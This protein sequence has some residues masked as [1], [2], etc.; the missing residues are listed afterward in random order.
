MANRI[1]VFRDRGAEVQDERN[2]SSIAA[3]FASCRDVTRCGSRYLDGNAGG[4]L[5]ARD[6]CQNAPVPYVQATES[7]LRLG[8]NPTVPGLIPPNTDFFSA[9][10][11]QFRDYIINASIAAPGA[12]AL[13]PGQSPIGNIG[14]PADFLPEAAWSLRG[15]SWIAEVAETADPTASMEYS[16]TFPRIVPIYDQCG[17]EIGYRA[18]ATVTM[19]YLTADCQ[20]ILYA[21]HSANFAYN[22]NFFTNPLTVRTVIDQL[23]TASYPQGGPPSI[24]TASLENCATLSQT[25]LTNW[26]DVNIPLL[27]VTN[28]VIVA[29][30]N[31]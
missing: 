4:G 29:D 2:G 21:V 6:G 19:T 16:L 11:T 8:D 27:T 1:Y 22:S 5:N 25:I 17:T 15:R 30:D 3:M 28:G 12:G 24:P 26:R 20:R 7:F 31:A 23:L 10:L 18:K 9:E 14:T 13:D